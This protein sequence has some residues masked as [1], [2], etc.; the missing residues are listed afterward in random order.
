MN[1]RH[2]NMKLFPLLGYNGKLLDN[3]KQNLPLSSASSV[4]CLSKLLSILNAS[5]S[6]VYFF[7]IF[8]RAVPCSTHDNDHPSFLSFQARPR[9]EE[10]PGALPCLQ[11][12]T[13]L[14]SLPCLSLLLLPPSLISAQLGG[15][16]NFDPIPFTIAKQHFNSQ[17][18]KSVL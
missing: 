9:S 8:L 18:G 14:R 17:S 16:N 4:V 10:E 11:C 1:L 6:F 7:E 5:H 3:I 15:A 2:F 13:M 12:L